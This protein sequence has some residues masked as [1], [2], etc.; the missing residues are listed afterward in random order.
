MSEPVGSR[1]M[2]AAQKGLDKPSQRL[3]WAPLLNGL[4]LVHSDHPVRWVVR[5]RL[6]EAGG[7]AWARLSAQTWRSQ[8]PGLRRRRQLP[9]RALPSPSEN[10]S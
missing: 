9:L 3:L 7:Q 2:L 6:Q 5:L 10:V 1:E 8:R 4:G